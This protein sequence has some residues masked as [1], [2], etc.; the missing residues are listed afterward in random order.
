VLLPLMVIWRPVASRTVLTE[1]EMVLA[2]VIV[3]SQANVTVPPPAIAAR[4]LDSVQLVTVPAARTGSCMSRHKAAKVD[5]ITAGGVRLGC[6]PLHL[7]HLSDFIKQTL[8]QSIT[9]L[10][11]IS[12][13]STVMQTIKG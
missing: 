12:Q 8:N 7:L 10:C 3:P 1:F 4:K 11:A 5:I 6:P 2:S 13:M 9:I